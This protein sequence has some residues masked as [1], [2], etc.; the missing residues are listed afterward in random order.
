MRVVWEGPQQWCG[1]TRH[2]D[3]PADFASLIGRIWTS[4]LSTMPHDA[5][6]EQCE[7]DSKS[8]WARVGHSVIQFASFD[9]LTLGVSSV[10]FRF[11]RRIEAELLGRLL[12]PWA[13]FRQKSSN[14]TR[15]RRVKL[16]V[17]ANFL[18]GFAK[19]VGC[20]ALV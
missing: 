5:S 2:L 20:L 1:T 3:P 13:A 7:H 10:G 18:T 12:S 4:P 15:S 17:I 9:E 14:K 16:D 6:T 19:A 11:P 8:C